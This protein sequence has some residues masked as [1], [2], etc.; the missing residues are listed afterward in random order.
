M[1]DQYD[2]GDTPAFEVG[3]FKPD[4]VTPATPTGLVTVVVTNIRTRQA[5][6]GNPVTAIS[7]NRVT[8]TVPASMTATPGFYRAATTIQVDSTPTIRTALYDYV[9]RKPV[10]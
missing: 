4:G 10:G 6:S 7:G 8:V 3:V 5:V 2:P 1:A 9:I